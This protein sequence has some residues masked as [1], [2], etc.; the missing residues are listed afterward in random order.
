MDIPLSNQSTDK[1][2]VVLSYLTMRKAIGILGIAFP[3]ILV[4]GSIVFGECSEVQK[5]IS[6]YYHTNMRNLFVAILSAVALFL[7]SYRGHD[8]MDNL[9]GY[10]GSL[11]ALGVAFLPCAVG[12]P[13]SACSLTHVI[14]KS[15]IGNLHLVSAALFFL[16]LIFYSLVLFTKTHKDEETGEN[17]EMPPKKK[18]RNRVF[19]ICGYLMLLCIMLIFLYMWKLKDIWPSLMEINPIFWLESFAL[20]FFGISWLTKGQMI[21]KDE[22]NNLS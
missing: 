3:I 11:F 8:W 13:P 2:P 14:H 20:L 12:D 17:L 1:P 18:S 4:F 6:A 10:L 19:K 7:F 9:A 5:S 22:E 16:V 21:L 15:I